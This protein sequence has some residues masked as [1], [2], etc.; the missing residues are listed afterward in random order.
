MQVSFVT[1]NFAAMSFSQRTTAL[2]REHGMQQQQQQQ[3]QQQSFADATGIDVQQSK[4]M[5]QLLIKEKGVAR[6][7]LEG[8]PLKHTAH[9][10][11]TMTQTP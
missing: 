6:A 10:L 9:R 1:A 11:N 5:G 4:T 2:R 3:Q 7:V 8:L